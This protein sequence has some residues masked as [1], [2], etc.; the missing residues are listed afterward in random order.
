LVGRLSIRIGLFEFIKLIP[1]EFRL[2]SSLTV[3]DTEDITDAWNKLK[4]FVSQNEQKYQSV[5]YHIFLYILRRF[6][7]YLW[8]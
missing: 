6:R 4:H 5:R 3:D 7:K 8:I 1:D 2:L